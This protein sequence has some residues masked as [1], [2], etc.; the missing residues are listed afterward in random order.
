M[1]DHQLLFL[2]LPPQI[3]LIAILQT[4]RPIITTRPRLRLKI[5]MLLGTGRQGFPLTNVAVI[6]IFTAPDHQFSRR[7]TPKS[8]IIA[9]NRFLPRIGPQSFEKLR[10]TA[11]RMSPF[12]LLSLLLGSDPELIVVAEG[13]YFFVFF[14]V[15]DRG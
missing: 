3:L 8:T 1:C 15:G 7:A 14:G 9:S 12:P 10:R 11:I 13:F 5:F 6:V 4:K 2:I